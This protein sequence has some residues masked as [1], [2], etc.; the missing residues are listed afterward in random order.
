LL[1]TSHHQLEK[2]QHSHVTRCTE[3]VPCWHSCLQMLALAVTPAK[4]HR[5]QLSSTC[6][7]WLSNLLTQNHTSHSNDPAVSSIYKSRGQPAS[8]YMKWRAGLTVLC[9]LVPTLLSHETPPIISPLQHP[10]HSQ[11]HCTKSTPR[12]HR[13]ITAQTSSE[14]LAHTADLGLALCWQQGGVDVGQYSACP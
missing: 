2:Q 7:A 1:G 11:A 5:M 3:P 14:L 10:Q 8:T 9:M 13:K 4:T 12:P 6:H